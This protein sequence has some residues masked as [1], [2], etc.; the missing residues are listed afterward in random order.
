[1]EQSAIY[2]ASQQPYAYAVG[3]DALR[4]RL[5]TRAGDCER[6]LA[7]YKNLYD[8]SSPFQTVE[9]KPILTDGIVTLYEGELRVPER[10]FKYWFE[11]R[12]QDET[13]HYTS[14][15]FLENVQERN[16]F[17]CPVIN[18]DDIIAPPEWAKGGIVYQIFVDRF[19][20]GEPANDPAGTVSPDVLPRHGTFYGGDLQGA[21]ERLE[22]VKALGAEMVYLSPVL[23]SPTYHKYDVADYYAVDDA[24]GGN[25]ALIA[26]VKQAH[27]LGLKV[28][29]DAVFNHCSDQNPLF[30]DVLANGARSPYAK[31]FYLDSFPVSAEP[32][33]Y[34]TFAGAVPSMPRFDTSNPD[35]IE[36][37]TNAALHW[38]NL[39]GLDGWRLD[40]ADE[41]SHSL[42]RELR[43]KLKTANPDILIIGE[44]WNHAGAWLRGDEFDTVTDYKLRSALIAFA[45][46]QIDSG[47]FWRA[48]SAN[49]MLYMTPQ[50]SFLLNF[51]GTHDTPRIATLLGGEQLQVLVLTAILTMEGIPLLYYGD[52]LGME[53]GED[54]DNRRAM[55]WDL[56]DSPLACEIR[57]LANFRAQSPALR[58]G[59]MEPVFAGDRALSFT[60]SYGEE[61]CA[62]VINFG[63]EEARLNGKYREVLLG[64]A[65]LEEN[66]VRV[67]AMRYAVVR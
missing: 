21:A 24:L 39:L 46:G 16:C 56:T 53:G 18:S 63:A 57:A 32:C 31:W 4:V 67:P 35:V 61:S 26:F 42:W 23:K 45:K 13:L 5:R 27:R 66:G 47:A 59:S 6:V 52:E 51:A 40:V 65:K 36:Y 17:Y 7:H 37:L 41:V 29:L 50:Y 15:G 44:V 38:T 25:E 30:Q 62:V 22:Y 54:P 48:A 55:R 60:R 11:L 33:N 20:N 43:R 3:K 1:M 2:H 34:D 28:I 49:A 9:M 19:Y 12:F 8:H 58:R 10:H 14:D 64:E